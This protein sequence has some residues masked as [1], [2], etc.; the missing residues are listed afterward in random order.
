MTKKPK[1]KDSATEFC[2][3]LAR[4]K[5]YIEWFDDDAYT[6]LEPPNKLLRI[7]RTGK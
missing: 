7:W 5:R 6:T 4:H 2:R 3:W 1:K